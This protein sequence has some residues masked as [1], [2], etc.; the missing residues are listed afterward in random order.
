MTPPKPATEGLA[1]SSGEEL[2][3]SKF[4]Y[5]FTRAT[6]GKNLGGGGKVGRNPLRGRVVGIG[7]FWREGFS[8]E[9]VARSNQVGQ[10]GRLRGNG[11][12]EMGEEVQKYEK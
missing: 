7:L 1:R 12:R 8:P 4:N 2:G 9:N 5:S 6:K 10:G 11:N 3:L